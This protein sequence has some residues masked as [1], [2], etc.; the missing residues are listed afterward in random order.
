MAS[1]VGGML[2][3]AEIKGCDS[4]PH[5]IHPSLK[6]QALDVGLSFSEPF[7][8][9]GSA[10]PDGALFPRSYACFLL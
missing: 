7:Y 6:V 2:R 3:Q 4:Y 8:S 9:E 10:M 5:C 1:A